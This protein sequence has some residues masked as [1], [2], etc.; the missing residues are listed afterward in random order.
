MTSRQVTTSLFRVRHAN[1][2]V[3]DGWRI[4]QH[5]SLVYTFEKTA[6][7][8]PESDETLVSGYLRR[9]VLLD[10]VLALNFDRAPFAAAMLAISPGWL[11]YT[12]PVL[13]YC[14]HP[15]PPAHFVKHP[16]VRYFIVI[17]PLGRVHAWGGRAL[18]VARM[19]DRLSMDAIRFLTQGTVCTFA[20]EQQPICDMRMI[21]DRN[22]AVTDDDAL[23]AVETRTVREW[24][25]EFEPD[26]A[27]VQLE[28]AD[29]AVW[30]AA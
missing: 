9:S 23:D 7:R 24:L 2:A 11:L 27:L 1:G 13:A 8:P 20:G 17:D 3:D 22:D 29:L 12:Q 5:D 21:A 15:S 19:L 6:T 25:V 28:V 26:P 18:R 16:I 10:N 14:W 30:G 4:Y